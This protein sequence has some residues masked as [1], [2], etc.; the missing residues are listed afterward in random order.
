MNRMILWTDSE[1]R[2]R[3]SIGW[4][5]P[6]P[7]FG[8]KPF[9]CWFVYYFYIGK[10]SRLSLSWLCLSLFNIGKYSRLS[11]ARLCLS[12]SNIV[13]VSIWKANSRSQNIVEKRR[14]WAISLFHNIFNISL[15]SGVKLHNSFVKCAYLAYFFLDFSNLICRGTDI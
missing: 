15:T 12:R 2:L 3:G 11:L 4:C 14:H 8:T 9:R 5:E 1:C 7:V 6:L 10:Y 13:P